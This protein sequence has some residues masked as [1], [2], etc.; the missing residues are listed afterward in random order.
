[1]TNQE[2]RRYST[3]LLTRLGFCLKICTIRLPNDHTFPRLI[4]CDWLNEISITVRS[5]RQV[6]KIEN[7]RAQRL[8]MLDSNLLLESLLKLLYSD[9]E[10]LQMQQNLVFDILIWIV[11]IRMVRYRYPKNP[12]AKKV[13]PTAEI[14]DAAT[15]DING[16]QSE[17]IQ[18]I[19]RHLEQAIRHC[20]VLGNRSIAHKCVKFVSVA[21]E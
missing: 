19:E 2:R 9:E 4:G 20:I 17:C 14:K 21:L 1:M 16:Q 6:Y 12:F 10:S 3:Y 11:S 18:I 15:A 13:I 8:A 7:E 5:T